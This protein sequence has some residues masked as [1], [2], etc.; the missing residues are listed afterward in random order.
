MLHKLLFFNC[1][2]WQCMTIYTWHSI[3]VQIR[4][5]NFKFPNNRKG[6]S[7]RRIHFLFHSPSLSQLAL[8]TE[9]MAVKF[10]MVGSSLTKCR[11]MFCFVFILYV[12]ISSFFINNLA[13]NLLMIESL[14]TKLMAQI[15]QTT[16]AVKK[17]RVWAVL[18]I[19]QVIQRD[20]GCYGITLYEN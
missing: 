14:S 4:N 11:Y 16:V 6:I 18:K 1:E 20:M 19:Q 8:W 2:Q 5:A 3:L 13:C 17:Q 15:V 7:F 12:I 9:P 10:K